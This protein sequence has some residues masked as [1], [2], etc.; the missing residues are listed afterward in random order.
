MSFEEETLE[1][2]KNVEARTF[3]ILITSSLSAGILVGMAL[4]K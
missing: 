4:M 2:L 3:L 1:R